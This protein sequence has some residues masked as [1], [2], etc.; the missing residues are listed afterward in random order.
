[1]IDILN[2]APESVRALSPEE[3][4]IR[5]IRL[6]YIRIVRGKAA[7]SN[8]FVHAQRVL[9]ILSIILSSFGS[10]GV[11]IDRMGTQPGRASAQPNVGEMG[12]TQPGQTGARPS[13][14]ATQP[15]QAGAQPNTGAASGAQPGEGG[16]GVYLP[17]VLLLFG[18]MSQIANEFGVARFASNSTKLADACKICETRLENVLSSEDD[19]RATVSALLLEVNKL[20]EE[21]Q[22]NAVLPKHTDELGQ[23]AKSIAEKAIGE[24]RTGWSL[25]VTQ[26]RGLIAD[27]GG[28]AEDDH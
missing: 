14:G 23:S 19:P 16:R 12:A 25:D 5:N 15:G 26:S 2:T 20:F 3:K 8:W 6:L 27:A 24:Y 13:P 4:L 22:F 28:Q 17:L 18:I 10:L 9:A 11:L 21:P 7:G 1:M